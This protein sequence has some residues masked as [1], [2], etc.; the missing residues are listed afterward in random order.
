MAGRLWLALLN[1]R[2]RSLLLAIAGIP[3]GISYVWNAFVQ[4]LL[5]PNL[6]PTDFQQAYLTAAA[7]IAAGHDPYG[8][9]H[10]AS[11]FEQLTNS[12]SVYPPLLGWL[13]QPVVNVNQTVLLIGALIVC[14]LAVITFLIATLVALRISDWQLIALCAMATLSY[15]PLL[16]QI[17]Y[18]N[19]QVVLL[20]ASG[21]WLLAWTKGDVWWGGMATGIGIALKLVQ[22]PTLLL[23]F[24]R[25]RLAMLIAALTVW[26]VLWAVAAAQYLPD[27]LF[28]VLPAAGGGTGYAKNIAPIATLARLLHPQSMGH[29]ELGTGVGQFERAI[30]MLVAVAALALTA[31]CLGRSSRPAELWPIEA[32]AAVAAAPLLSTLLWPGQLTLLL[33]PFVV[34]IAFAVRAADWRMLT[35]IALAWALTGPIY[36]AF[37]NAYAAGYYG[38]P[39]MRPWAECALAGVVLLWAAVLIALRKYPS[40]ATSRTGQSAAAG[41]QPEPVAV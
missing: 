3:I 12:A 32:A 23:I 22:A 20:G 8:P 41:S 13:L 38:L 2:F 40:R 10:N 18:Q 34:M 5:S 17:R 9:C 39:I 27:Y 28:R 15:P 29:P 14:Q 33:L 24:W 36:L 25:R 26:V 6:V 16:D 11:C 19:V 7:S 31:Y 30:A 37:T 1:R 35:S 4:P 21:I